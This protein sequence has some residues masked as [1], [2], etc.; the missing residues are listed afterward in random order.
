[1][2]DV[3][4]SG[5]LEG[6]GSLSGTQKITVKGIGT[7]VGDASGSATVV[8]VFEGA[9]ELQGIGGILGLGGVWTYAEGT[10]AGDG[11]MLGML[12]QVTAFDG[13]VSVGIKTYN[14][15]QI[16]D[17]LSNSIQVVD[18]KYFPRTIGEA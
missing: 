11:S 1:M 17:T 2:A 15:I 14:S 18:Q 7:L 8:K 12:R 6:A 13:S 3:F 16:Y 5:V 9:G 10:L 4:G